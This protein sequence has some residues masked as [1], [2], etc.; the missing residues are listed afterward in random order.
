MQQKTRQ[1]E[2]TVK[3]CKLRENSKHD[4]KENDRDKNTENTNEVDGP[5]GR[6]DMANGSNI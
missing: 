4:I 1:C 3:Y 5:I 6:W 2:K